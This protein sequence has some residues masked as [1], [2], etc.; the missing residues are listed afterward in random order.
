MMYKNMLKGIDEKI[1]FINKMN[2]N[3][4]KSIIM[5]ALADELWKSA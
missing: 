1:P 3:N 5:G 4:M 2:F